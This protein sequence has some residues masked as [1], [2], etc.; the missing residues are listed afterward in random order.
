MNTHV[1]NTDI[2]IK[3]YK[4]KPITYQLQYVII[5]RSMARHSS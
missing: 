3:T 1:Y 2:E 4:T 5:Y